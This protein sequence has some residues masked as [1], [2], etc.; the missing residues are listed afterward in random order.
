MLDIAL[1]GVVLY[2]REGYSERR[3]DALRRLIESRG[4]GA[5]G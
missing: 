2:D 3:L 4:C 1:E 5:S